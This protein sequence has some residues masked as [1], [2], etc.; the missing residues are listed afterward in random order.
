MRSFLKFLKTTILGGIFFLF[1]LILIIL[2]F[3]KAW[4]A[5]TKIVEPIAHLIPFPD[6]FG[7]KMSYL[8]TILIFV[9]IGFFSGL[10]AKTRLAKRFRK[11]A[12]QI[13]E[14]IPGYS[15]LRVFA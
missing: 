7:L 6:F 11:S 12:E 3:S 2:I 15:L 4:K 8:I 13:I 10:I 1:P 14:K 5:V 9:A